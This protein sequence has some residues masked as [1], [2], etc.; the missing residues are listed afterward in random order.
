M[1]YVFISARDMKGSRPSAN[2]KMSL[3]FSAARAL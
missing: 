3:Q 1:A 2:E